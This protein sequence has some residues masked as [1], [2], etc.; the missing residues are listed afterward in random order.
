MS[1]VDGLCLS[2][3][4]SHPRNTDKHKAVELGHSL[5]IDSD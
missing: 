2:V 5:M 1:Q 4:N 3:K